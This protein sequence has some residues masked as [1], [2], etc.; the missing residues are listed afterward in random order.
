MRVCGAVVISFRRV[1][2]RVPPST[3]NPPPGPGP[4]G[5]ETARWGPIGERAAWTIRKK[6]AEGGADEESERAT[7]APLT[8]RCN[9]PG[10]FYRSRLQNVQ[11]DPR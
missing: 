7:G 9:G 8:A 6:T 2:A 10:I 5:S 1:L 11:N 4:G 3:R